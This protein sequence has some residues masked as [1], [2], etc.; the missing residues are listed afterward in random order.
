MIYNTIQHEIR[1]NANLSLLD[2]CLLESIY[3][4]SRSPKAKYKS[5]CYAS[6]NAFRYLATS[7]TIL[8]RL[9]HLEKI[10]F[11]EFKEGQ[12]LLK[13]TTKKYFEEVYTYVLGTK[14]L[15]TKGTKKLPTPYE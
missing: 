10:G 3:Q 8:T 4:L 1:N 15:P 2:W 7:R 11:I 13:R 9:N 5:W 6:K 12:R 14:K